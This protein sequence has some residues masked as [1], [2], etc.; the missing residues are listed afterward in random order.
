M[1]TVSLTP[2][3]FR[4]AALTQERNSLFTYP[5]ERLAEI[6]R[7]IGFSCTSCAKCC[8]R[9]FNGH[10]FLLDRDVTAIKAIDGGAIE[11]A[12]APE[13]CDQNGVFY[14]SGYA[15]KTKADDEGS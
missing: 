9:K 10:V 5:L 4:I 12:P 3:P 2:I 13:F 8:T 1:V 7:E 6:I 11:P 14:V 15:L